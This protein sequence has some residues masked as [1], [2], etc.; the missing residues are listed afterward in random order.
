MIADR[1]LSNWNDHVSR[2]GDVTYALNA[3]AAT[4]DARVAEPANPFTRTQIHVA[5]AMIAVQL[6]VSADE[7]VDRLRAFAF[8]TGRRLC[9]VAADV[10]A[11]RL[12][13][14]H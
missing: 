4:H 11:R 6:R 7:G 14:H 13:L 8:A 10:I 5:G 12:S 3:V 2:F 1:L 9:S